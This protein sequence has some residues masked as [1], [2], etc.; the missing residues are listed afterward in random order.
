M[1]HC[2]K[3]H[4]HPS[5]HTCRICKAPGCSSCVSH[6]L[7]LCERCF[8]KLLIVLF[9]AMILVSYTAWFGVF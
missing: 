4:G 5:T 1:T 9:A 6:P 2:A 7:L 8:Y 3:H